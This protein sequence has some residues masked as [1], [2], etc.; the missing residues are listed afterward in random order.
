LPANKVDS[1]SEQRNA[2][3][4]RVVR[5]VLVPMRGGIR[6]A[7]NLYLPDAAG[8]FPPLLM[9][10]PYLK[11]GPG[12]RGPAEVVQESLARRGYACLTLDMRGFGASEGRADP[13]FSP[14]ERQDGF[15]ALEWMAAQSWCTGKTGMWGISHGPAVVGCALGGRSGARRHCLGRRGL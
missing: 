1:E 11:D 10:T 15:A 7:G 14:I 4:V 8:P 3:S 5:D 13:P 2:P 9:Y 6:L 12:G